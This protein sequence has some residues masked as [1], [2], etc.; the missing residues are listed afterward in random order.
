MTCGSTYHALLPAAVLP[1]GESWAAYG[2]PGLLGAN[3]D[4]FRRGFPS[5]SRH[6]I[7]RTQGDS[8]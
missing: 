4:E 5:V 7:N 2:A 6:P 1:T 3:G 8:Q